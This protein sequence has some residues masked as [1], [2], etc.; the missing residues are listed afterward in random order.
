[1][2]EILTYK[3]STEFTAYAQAPVLHANL[4]ASWVESDGNTQT[5]TTAELETFRQ[6]FA[7][8]TT[9]ASL[10]NTI[11]IEDQ[12]SLTHLLNWVDAELQHEVDS[13]NYDVLLPFLN[14]QNSVITSAPETCFNIHFLIFWFAC[15]SQEQQKQL[16]PALV[17][18]LPSNLTE[19]DQ[20]RAFILATTLII[21]TLA[22]EQSSQYP[23]AAEVASIAAFLDFTLM[24]IAADDIKIIVDSSA[25][26]SKAGEYDP[27]NDTLYISI[28]H[29]DMTP[30]VVIHELY[31]RFQD[32]KSEP[33]SFADAEFEAHLAGTI[34]DL[35]SLA[36]LQPSLA[37]RKILKTQ[38]PPDF[39]TMWQLRNPVAANPIENYAAGL[40]LLDS[41]REPKT[42]D[43]NLAKAKC[44]QNL[45]LSYKRQS[46]AAVE[47][48]VSA[49]DPVQKG[50]LLEQL[51][52]FKN[53]FTAPQL[54]TA[55]AEQSATITFAN[56][57]LYYALKM[58][59]LKQEWQKSFYRKHVIE[60][61]LTSFDFTVIPSGFDG[62]T[63]GE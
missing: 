21:L 36:A 34:L 20:P 30:Q 29:A 50:V 60:P 11:Y 58:D 4:W 39:N 38:T 31:H 44:L 28:N 25:N 43:L 1:M 19:T 8:E 15:L 48:E 49:I 26:P 42:N 59:S 56:A 17:K 14:T 22:K 46:F 52:V 12:L 23:N 40:L 5:F 57:L 54:A 18:I 33:Q 3:E 27:Q 45:I 24:T 37:S 53:Q 61:F 62:I 32:S 7:P 9:T 63:N 47:Q 55:I 6:K 16:T 2:V 35:M 10:K 13:K 41:D 51:A